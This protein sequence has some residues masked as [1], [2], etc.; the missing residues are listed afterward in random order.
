MLSMRVKATVVEV[1]KA[2]L[3]AAMDS[4]VGLVR[5]YQHGTANR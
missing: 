4:C 1:G 5:P 3:P 2:L